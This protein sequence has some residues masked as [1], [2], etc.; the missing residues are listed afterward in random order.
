MQSARVGHF[1]LLEK[2]GEGGMGQV[3]KARD[4]RLE[5]FVAVKVLSDSRLADPGSRSR[6]TQEAKAASALNHPNIIVVHEIG[7]HDRQIYIVMEL[8]DGKPLSQLIPKKGMRLTEALHI[9]VEIADALAAAHA[10]GIVHRDLKPANLMVDR[11]GRAKVLDF[12][13]AKMT[14]SA[15]VATD[16]ETRT[17]AVTQLQTEEGVIM[18]S[19]PYMSPEQ[20]EGR[21]VDARS[22]IFSFGAV[23]YE[24]ITGRRAFGGESRVSTLAAVVEKD[25]VP[26][27]EIAAGTPPELER[28]IARCLRKEVGR[29]SQSMADVKLALEEL[30]DEADSGKLARPHIAAPGTNGASRWFWPALAG[31]CVLI[32]VASFAFAWLNHRA[33]ASPQGPDLVRLSPDDRHSYS[34][35]TISPD[36]KFVAFISE[37]SGRRQLWLQQVGGGEPIQLTHSNETVS[38]ASFFPDGTRIVYSTASSDRRRTSTIE[39]IPTLGGQ[40]RSLLNGTDFGGVALSPD[41]QRIVYVDSGQPSPRL[42]IISSDGGPPREL[43][44]WERTQ[45]QFKIE[46]AIWTSDSRW[47]LCTGSKRTQPDEWDWFAVP[48]DGGGPVATGAGAAL[49]AAGLRMSS[50]RLMTG[51]RVLFGAGRARRVN[52]WEIRLSPRSWRA[53]G[54]PR[55]LTFGTMNE[56]PWAISD[57]GTVAIEASNSSSDLYAIPFSPVTGQPTDR[58]RRLTQD[59]RFKALIMVQ[60]D[61]GAAYIGV[62]DRNSNTF[63]FNGYGLNLESARQTLLFPGLGADSRVM[64]T[65]DGQHV[66]YSIPENGAYSIHIGDVGA[67]APPARVLCK[68]C[69]V[70]LRFSSD[71][72][73]LFYSPE[74][75]TDSNRKHTIRL[76]EVAS[77]NDHAW[78]EHPSDSITGIG[79]FGRDRAW[80]A[81]LTSSP[82]STDRSSKYIVPWREAPVPF[83]EWIEIRI[84]TA[85]FNFSLTGDF[86]YYFRGPEMMTVRFDAK[87]RRVS[88]PYE[89]KFVPGSAVT[90]KAEDQW[91]IRGSTIVFMSADRT[92]SVWLMK[93]PH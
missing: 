49:R 54:P 31:T 72:R 40:S 68:S 85:N 91:S 88:E 12:G 9:A 58:T 81:V 18:G 37:R 24:M 78:L 38:S 8:V 65:E 47:V 93:L 67:A 45:S 53:N 13:L 50:P 86:F 42:M 44:N 61:P 59:E 17:L 32:A 74:T 76:L 60:G 43:A 30:R 57:T 4:T 90:V 83:A 15:A 92:S 5:R 84:P 16:E 7:E 29:R 25:P 82:G 79:T 51:D 14:A 41:G 6:F 35:P 70:A 27:S 64:M 19:I 62:E 80:L 28:L 71:G 87:S 26:P 77:G 39:V 69:G 89:V 46:Q 56:W 1:G 10:A 66:A 22:D 33:G 11:L 75:G 2:I 34:D 3:Y 52:A 36:G 21:P 20:A 73:F 23:L 55:Q 48:V 63:R